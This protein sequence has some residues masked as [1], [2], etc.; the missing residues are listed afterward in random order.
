MRNLQFSRFPLITLLFVA[1]MMLLAASPGSPQSQEKVYSSLI[2]NF[3]R[4]IEWPRQS[5]N[6]FVIGIYEYNPLADELRTMSAAFKVG[7]K[8]IVVKNLTNTDEAASCNV[9]FVPAYK[10]RSMAAFLEK[11]KN[12]PTL[13]IT[14]TTNMAKNGSGV[15]F[16]LID[17]KLQYEINCRGI[18]SRGMKISAK[19]KGMGIVVD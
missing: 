3:S 15:N 13:I 12:S 17:G 18:E 11:L 16:V 14:N 1:I 8:K 4:G 6:E 2:L 10:S 19:I 5:T 9:L 7:S